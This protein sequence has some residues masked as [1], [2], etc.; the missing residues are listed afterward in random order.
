MGNITDNLSRHEFACKCGCGFDSM[1][2]TTIEIT[3]DVCDYFRCKAIINSAA[4]CFKYNRSDSV[5]SNDNSQHPLARALDCT[6]ETV[7]TSDVYEYLCGKYPNQY[8]FGVY[9]T[10]NH[11]DSR[12]NGPARWDKRTN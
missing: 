1:D 6:F 11:I 10:F 8:G 7:S 9:N 3:Q 4:R 12:T 2:I 5:G